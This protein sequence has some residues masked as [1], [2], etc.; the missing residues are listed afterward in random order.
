MRRLHAFL[1]ESDE[2]SV[3]RHHRRCAKE[4]AARMSQSSGQ[5]SADG[6]TDVSPRRTVT[7]RTVSRKSVRGARSSR[8]SDMVSLPQPEAYT[9][10]AMMDL[11]L[12]RFAGL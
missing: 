2:E 10:Q 3:C 9:V 7:R 12:P 11:A 5:D 1:E 4:M 6:T 8:A